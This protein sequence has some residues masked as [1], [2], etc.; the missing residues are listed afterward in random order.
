MKNCPLLLA[1]LLLTS[2]LTAAEDPWERLQLGMPAGEAIALLGDPVVSSRGGGFLKLN[3]DGGAEVLLYG[4]GRVVGWTAPA[5][6]GG[7]KHSHDIWSSQPA[8]KY[9]ATM[10]A[11]LPRPVRNQE[12]RV[13]RRAA[14]DGAAATGTGYEE[15]SARRRAG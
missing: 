9:Y 15:Y 11:I 2:S 8:G 5:G 3:Y 4:D 7:A 13:V 14:G 1:G 6:S 10:H 12:A